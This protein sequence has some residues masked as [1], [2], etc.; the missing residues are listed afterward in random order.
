[1]K[2]SA[3][4]AALG[5]QPVV[6]PIWSTLKIGVDFIGALP[7]APKEGLVSNSKNRKNG[8]ETQPIVSKTRRMQRRP[9]EAATLHRH[10][11]RANAI[12]FVRRHFLR[13]AAGATALPAISN[14]SWAQ[15]YPARPITVVVPYPAGGPTDVVARIITD[16]MRVALGQSVLIENVSGASGTIALS[17]VARA[18]PD[19]YTAARCQPRP[20]PGGSAIGREWIHAQGR[21][22]SGPPGVLR[23]RRRWRGWRG[24]LSAQRHFCSPQSLPPYELQRGCRLTIVEEIIVL[25]VFSLIH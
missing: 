3:P 5:S 15:T 12:R 14:M 23:P 11:F 9:V 25:I 24:A 20:A 1:M 18:P 7:A 2:P 19:G 8:A 16:R 22:R 6:S 17:R 13:L 4:P 21:A 10:P